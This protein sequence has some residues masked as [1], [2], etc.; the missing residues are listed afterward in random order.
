MK[1]DDY[2]DTKYRIPFILLLLNFYTNIVMRSSAKTT[3][4]LKSKSILSFFQPRETRENLRTATLSSIP[5]SD[6]SPE[7]P[8]KRRK[9]AD[10]VEITLSGQAVVSQFST[11]RNCANEGNS[12][13]SSSSNAII[14]EPLKLLNTDW[15]SR[16]EPEFTKKYFKNL[17]DFLE[18]ESMKQSPIYPPSS[19]IFSAFNLCSFN[20]C[21]VVIIG[22]ASN[23]CFV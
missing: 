12:S 11:E 1:T 2:R 4:V 10:K 8:S 7:T 21:R 3:S 19:E 20:N 23:N 16:L 6:D 13:G 15:Y 18:I 17:Q 14:W 22:D 9:V 5:D